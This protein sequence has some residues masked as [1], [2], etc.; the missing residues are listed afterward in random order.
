MFRNMLKDCKIVRIMNAIAAN[1]NGTQTGTVVTMDGFDSVCAVL[2]LAAVT[3]T[4]TV[5]LRAGDGSLS[6]G[7][8]KAN[9]AGAS[10]TLTASTSSNFQ[11]VLDV[12]KPLLEYVTF[13]VDQA[14]ANS[15]IGSMTAYLYNAKNIPV[16]QPSSVAA[17]TFKVANS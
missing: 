1:S 6:N 16:T 7:A 17:S 8:D 2:D 10:A 13:S 9:I 11:V 12:Q 3:D 5:T 4:A 14:V 15:A